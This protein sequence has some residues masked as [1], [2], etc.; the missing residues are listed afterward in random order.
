MAKENEQ[1]FVLIYSNDTFDIYYDKDTKRYH[2]DVFNDG[3]FWDEVWFDEYKKP[4]FL[5]RILNRLEEINKDCCE[6]Y[7]NDR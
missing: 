4:N 6:M 2:I 1:S 5:E 7:L 3:H